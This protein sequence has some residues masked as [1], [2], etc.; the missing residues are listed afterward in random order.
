VIRIYTTK[1]IKHKVESVINDFRTNDI[2][3]ICEKLGIT[4]LRHNLGRV[5]G[6]LQYYENA[7]HYLI[8]V[9]ENFYCEKLVIAHELGHF[10]LH[11]NVNTFKIANCSVVLENKLEHQANVFASEILLTDKMLTDALPEI[12]NMTHR[13]IASFFQLPLFVIEYKVSQLRLLSRT[14]ELSIPHYL[15]QYA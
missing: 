3:E 8:H 12:E 5:K 15:V 4:I 6:F 7:D 13:Q 11:K 9:N 10:F 1:N 2:H 14:R